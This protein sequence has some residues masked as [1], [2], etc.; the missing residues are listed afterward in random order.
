MATAPRRRPPAP[1]SGNNLQVEVPTYDEAT[2]ESILST[3]DWSKEETDYLVNVYQECN[4]KWPVIVDRYDWG[5]P[6][7]SMEDL[8]AR[9]YHISAKLLQRQTPITAMTGPQY[10]LYETLSKFDPKQEADRK[11]LADAHLFRGKAEVDEEA[12]LLSELQRIM[13]NQGAV[14]TEREVR[15][16][17]V[18][19]LTEV[20][21][22]C[23]DL[24]RRLDYPRANSNGYSYTS[25]QALTGLWQQLL[26]ADRMKKNQRLRPTG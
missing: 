5:V 14:D 22:L 19:L 4:G 15:G 21:D 7:R 6:T 9:F 11:R 23:Q 26:A 8:K 20:T 16:L 1:F 12:V 2:F 24:R 25:S 13:K 18:F 10:S 17:Q 3:P